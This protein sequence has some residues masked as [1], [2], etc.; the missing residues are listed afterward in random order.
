[1][2]KLTVFRSDMLH[3]LETNIKEQAIALVKLTSI[4]VGYRKIKHR[5]AP[6]SRRYVATVGHHNQKPLTPLAIL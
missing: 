3:R 5:L 4:L 6:T 1:M 2:K